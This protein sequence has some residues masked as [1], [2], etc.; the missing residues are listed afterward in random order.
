MDER[1]AR[2]A[3]DLIELRRFPGAAK[4]FWPRFL[5]AC[6]Q[7]AL[8]DMAVLM[9]GKPGQSPRWQKIGECTSGP[10]QPGLRSAFQAFVDQAAG[11]ALA[12]DRF[13]EEDDETSGAFTLGLRLKLLR[14][15]D[16]VVLVAQVLDF[17]ESAAR[18]ALARLALAADTPALYQGHLAARQAQNDVEKFA[19]VL[20]LMVPVNAEKRFLAAALALCNA[21]AARL[22][23]E[24]VSLGWREGGYVKLKTISRTEKFDRQMAAA[25]ALEA[26]MEECV[27]QDEEVIFPA[28]D[29]TTAVTRDHEKYAKE[30]N[31]G[32]VVT[33]PL[34]REGEPVAVLACERVASAFS[35]TELQQLRLLCDQLTPRLVELKKFD[36][37]FGARWV[38]SARETFAK[39]LGP[40]RTWTKVAAIAS[41]AAVLSLFL[42]RLPYRVEGKFIVRSDAVSYLTAPF[43]GY[44]DE[45]PVRPG[46]FLEKGGVVV[47][48]DRSELELEQSAAQAEIGRYEREMEKARAAKSLAEMRIAEALVRQAKARLELI[49]HRLDAAA[50]RA[51]FEGVVVEG[52]LRERIASPVKTGEPLYKVARLDGL[53]IEAEVNERDVK[54]ILNSST[55]EFAFVTQPKR[56]FAAKVKSIEPAALAKKESNIFLVRLSPVDAA[57]PWWRPGMTGVCKIN[58]EKRTLWWIF[59]HRTVDFLRMKLWW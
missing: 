51:P 8:A 16:E 3:S 32:H 36:R 28:P 40:E 38:A 55:A 4:D 54:E 18:D 58:V 45:V 37:W 56:K 29:G 50:I 25:Q 13:V 6:A 20:D 15:E 26:A 49:N 53:T 33:V 9:V 23:C 34:R 39:A 14:P 7:L 1:F 44:I 43:D 35:Q 41:T 42:V 12:E 24:R 27:E 22:E 59:T 46:D 57:E 10:G 52:D 17:T 5:Q 47:T 30:Q 11:R 2:A 21:T 31:A 19:T 48:L